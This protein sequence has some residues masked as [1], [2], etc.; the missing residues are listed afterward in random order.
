M[1]FTDLNLNSALLNA[2]GDLEFETPTPI[3][4]QSF[5]VVMSGKDVVGIAQTGTGKTLAYLLPILR[6]LPFSKQKNPRVLILVPTRELVIQVV[7]EIEKL[8]KYTNNRV[9]GIFA[10][11][12]INTQKQE[13]SG[14]ADIVVATP[15]RLYDLALARAISLKS[16]QKLVIDEVDVMLDLGFKFQIQ[17]IVE[18]LPQQRQGILFSAT[19]TESVEEIIDNSF[20]DP[21]KISVAVSGTPLDNITQQRYEALNFY[22]KLNLLEDLLSDRETYT[23]TI[24]FVSSKRMAD[25]IL[26][27]MEAI[28]KGEAC[29]IHANKNQNYRLRSIEQFESGQCRLLIATD[30][31][32]RGIDF[33]GVSQVISLDTPEYPENYIHRIGRTGRAEKKGLSILFSTEK[34]LPFVDHIQEL[35]KMKIDLLPFPNNVTINEE[36][37]P[38]EKPR[39]KFKETNKI[40]KNKSEEEGGSAF[41]EKSAKNSKEN[42][43][44]KYRREIGF[45]YKKPKTKHS[46]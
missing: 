23:K 11:S 26:E 5:P 24:V 36:L 39:I 20:I 8:S 17:N 12:N 13:V 32:A 33:D 28:F 38:E 19:M 22:T 15:G 9:L 44:G 10:G 21:V 6:V 1:K 43:G 42:L 2:L 27:R 16:I 14:G 29:V 37:T 34:E 3:Q 41:H 31:M 4:E 18:L 35:M 45:K 46:K 40:H 7:N 30:V 25:R